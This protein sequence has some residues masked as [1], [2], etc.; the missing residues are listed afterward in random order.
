MKGPLLSCSSQL[1]A[2]S[3]LSSCVPVS[4]PPLQHTY[5]HWQILSPSLFFCNIIL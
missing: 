5:S 1:L 2:S 3:P 4:P